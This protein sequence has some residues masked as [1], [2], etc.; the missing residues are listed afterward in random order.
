MVA[1]TPISREL[2]KA[3]ISSTNTREQMRQLVRG[4]LKERYAGKQEFEKTS[5]AEFEL[6]LLAEDGKPGNHQTLMGALTAYEEWSITHL[7][8]RTAGQEYYYYN[9]GDDIVVHNGMIPCQM[10]NAF[11]AK[12][13]EY[14]I[15]KMK[16]PGGIELTVEAGSGTIEI[17][18]YPTIKTVNWIDDFVEFLQKLVHVASGLGLSVVRCGMQPFTSPNDLD[19]LFTEG[20]RY[21][22]LKNV[23]REPREIPPW[24]SDVKD[25]VFEA[26]WQKGVLNVAQTS[27]SQAHV[28]LGS[29]DEEVRVH[30]V[31]NKI[32]PL[33]MFLYPSSG[34]YNGQ[35]GRIVEPRES[36]WQSFAEENAGLFEREL[37]ID[38]L[39]EAY[40]DAILA[41][42]PH[43]DGS[44]TEFNRPLRELDPEV[45]KQ[46]SKIFDMLVGTF[47]KVLRGTGIPTAEFRAVGNFSPFSEGMTLKEQ[48][49]EM[50]QVPTLF[51][52]LVF[53][54]DEVEA[55]LKK[56]NVTVEQSEKW[57]R[58][59]MLMDRSSLLED[60]VFFAL[61]R[62][63]PELAIAALEN[64]N[65]DDDAHLLRSL[66][67]RI[68]QSGPQGLLAEP[69]A[70][71]IFTEKGKAAFLK[72]ISLPQE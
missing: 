12:P 44:F 28:S 56:F 52:G 31:F 45:F 57:Y 72:H 60:P 4:K 24:V 26:F 18:V 48:V 39:V 62:Q 67:E 22:A 8:D 58:Q 47:W 1:T 20:V 21:Q 61:L 41:L 54:L 10:K 23:L 27:S 66:R 14:F 19:K 15:K 2:P 70:V 42:I 30:N 49:K 7:V 65:H 69:L 59:V 11:E 29:L 9:P 16:G 43:E 35:V 17:N 32:L 63:L 3:F 50:L 46:N 37:T 64:I 25:P 68:H 51:K 40:L 33:I 55:L 6:L 53:A 5:G 71:K 36:L 34:V 38:L 13:H